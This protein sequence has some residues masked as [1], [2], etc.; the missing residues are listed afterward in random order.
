MKPD[1]TLNSTPVVGKV[2]M[3]PV[4]QRMEQL[5]PETWYE[6]LDLWLETWLSV[7]N[8]YEM[9]LS[10]STEVKNFAK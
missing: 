1:E 5:W 4:N 3:Q 7:S 8:G 10:S 9:K 6:T 2:R